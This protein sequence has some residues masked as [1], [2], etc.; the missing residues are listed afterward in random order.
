VGG[1]YLFGQLS[2]GYGQKKLGNSCY[3]IQ[4]ASCDHL[5]EYIAGSMRSGNTYTAS[6]TVELI[7]KIVAN[8]NTMI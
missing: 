4:F 8:S 2:K 5:M 6:G 7:K 1:Q 3:N